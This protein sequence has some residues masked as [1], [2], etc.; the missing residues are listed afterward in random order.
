[1]K[2]KYWSIH[3]CFH[4]Q[5][6]RGKIQVYWMVFSQH[7]SSNMGSPHVG[8]RNS[9]L[10]YTGGLKYNWAKKLFILEPT[11]QVSG[12]HPRPF[13]ILIYDTTRLVFSCRNLYRWKL[14]SGNKEIRIGY[15]MDQFLF[16]P[17]IDPIREF[18]LQK[19]H[20]SMST[21]NLS[22]YLIRNLNNR[23]C[24]QLLDEVVLDPMITSTV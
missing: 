22:L 11:G 7:I 5:E 24:D 12:T 4:W 20:N 21:S 17:W 2:S 1:M 13:L 9:D 19:K 15:I 6:F 16:D 14:Q 8:S 18:K 3:T 23:V 10:Y